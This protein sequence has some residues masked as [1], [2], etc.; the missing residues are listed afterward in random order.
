VG[1]RA[2]VPAKIER[3]LDDVDNIALYKEVWKTLSE[4]AA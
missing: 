3:W 2:T 1:G 4:S